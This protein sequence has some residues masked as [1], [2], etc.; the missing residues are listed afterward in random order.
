LSVL[1]RAHASKYPRIPTICIRRASS[2]FLPSREGRKRLL[3]REHI[4]SSNYLETL[5][6]VRDGFIGAAIS[7]LAGLV[8]AGL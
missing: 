8:G 1:P 2:F 3:Q 6:I 4:H 7:A 5:D